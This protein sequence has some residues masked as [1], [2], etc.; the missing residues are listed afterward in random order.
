MNNDEWKFQWKR[1]RLQRITRNDRE[2][3]T[4]LHRCYSIFLVLSCH[5]NFYSWSSSSNVEIHNHSFIQNM[6]AQW[7]GSLV[8]SQKSFK[9]KLGIN[10]E[11]RTYQS[12]KHI[13]KTKS[14]H[15]WMNLKP[16]SLSSRNA[17]WLCKAL[18]LPTLP[19]AS[20][21]WYI[22]WRCLKQNS[23]HSK[24]AFFYRMGTCFHIP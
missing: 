8:K 16:Y 10:H 6:L 14:I 22:N 7:N 20:K 23:K 24:L 1:G 11:I 2:K 12:M 15:A 9:N 4:Y 18:N 19:Q 17:Q 21:Q 5:P 3:N 13:L